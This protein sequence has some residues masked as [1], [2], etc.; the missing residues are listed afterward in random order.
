MTEPGRRPRPKAAGSS[1]P[2]PADF[3]RLTARVKLVAD[4]TRLGMLLRLSDGER[5]AGDIVLPRPP[6][7]Q[8]SPLGR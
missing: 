2:D 4:P 5:H 6:D 3:R 1:V 7:H 8:A